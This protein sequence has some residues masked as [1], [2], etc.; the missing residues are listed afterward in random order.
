MVNDRSGPSSLPYQ[1]GDTEGVVST[2]QGGTTPPN[3]S[4]VK[5]WNDH[6]PSK[7]RNPLIPAVENPPSP[8]FAKG[9]W[10]DFGHASFLS[11]LQLADSFFPTGMYAHSHGLEGMVRRGLV[12]AATEVEEL[13]ACQ[14]AWSVL[15]SDG[16]ALLNAY[17]VLQGKDDL[18]TVLEID[19]LLWAM[20]LPTELRAAAGQHGRR[21]LQETA[22]LV[23]HPMHARYLASVN[24]KEAPGCG[25]VVLGVVSYCLDIPAEWA[26][27]AYCH[28]YSVGVLSAGMKLLPMSHR[29]VQDILHRLQPLV[30]E[31]TQEIGA[32][33]WQEMTSFTPELD[34]ASMVHEGGQGAGD[35][36]MFAS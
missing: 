5:G 15:P 31:L 1:G 22:H 25:A 4:L 8:P 32:R 29:H 16:V 36:R 33:P 11:A 19:R 24:A 34:I 26:L 13:L 10:G 12:G 35:L 27:L 21:L 20:K 7:S 30:L 17:R 18:A 23:S 3:L 6:T 9:G 2:P 28:S 14:L